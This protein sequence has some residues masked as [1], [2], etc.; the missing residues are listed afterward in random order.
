MENILR[1]MRSFKPAEVILIF[2]FLLAPFYYHPNIGG[3][4]LRIPNN[5]TVWLVAVI[6]IL[7][8]V[9]KVITSTYFRIP[10]YF[11]FIASF[12]VL[13]LVSGFVTGVE[14]PLNWLFRVLF[15]L[16]GLTFFFSLFQHNI[17]QGRWDRLLYI[18]AIT[19]G[20][21][22]SMGIIQIWKNADIPYFLPASIHGIPFGFFQQINV[23]VIY[24]VTS[25]S[26]ALYLAS[27]PLLFRRRLLMQLCLAFTVFLASYVIGI[28]GSRVGTLSLIIS[29]S[30]LVIALFRPLLRN[31][32]LFA[33]ILG[34]I[35]LGYLSALIPNSGVD[36]TKL[37]NKISKMQSGYSGDSRF[38]IYSISID[39]IKEKPLFGH[40]IGSFAHDFQLARPNFYS[41]HPDAVLPP[42]LVGHPHN[43]IIFWLIE[44]GLLGLLGIIFVVIGGILALMQVGY[45]RGF[46]YAALIMP[47]AL[48]TQVSLPFYMSSTHW[49]L[50]ILLFS[51]PFR[52]Y[53]VNKSNVMTFSAKR[54][55]RL[56]LWLTT[57]L[58]ILF[59]FH[60]MR[61][62]WDFVDF[63]RGENLDK[64]LPYAYQNPYLREQ[65][66]WHDMSSFLYS[67]M[68][69]GLTD[70][71][72]YYADWGQTYLDK[73]PDVALYKKLIDA[74]Q[75]LGDR[76]NYCLTAKSGLV[77][78]PET[79]QLKQAVD[80]CQE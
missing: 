45:S 66:V 22:A 69:Q 71:V 70:N 29:V 27:R 53:L 21:H 61:S 5:N 37:E 80:I 19:G 79:E 52:H 60:T 39:L 62:N 16:G 10:R 33:A 31:K 12:P 40:G 2:L 76:E 24:L 72:R 73:R 23:Q 28:S 7:Y 48:H 49:F 15:I 59:L 26:I 67:S 41:E 77:I 43:E 25:I 47:I 78:Y 8:S 50:F 65:A 14:Q 34:L 4:G 55:S 56:F 32:T 68:E 64:P 30:T 18:I 35:T 9:N 20:I 36:Q 1:F 11:A 42:D 44:S 75:F 51:F 13:I 57:C 63:Y 58:A 54:L 38:G 3:N 46:A 6:F 74:Y 17:R